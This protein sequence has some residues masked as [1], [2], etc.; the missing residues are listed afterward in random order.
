MLPETI[1]GK[2]PSGRSEVMSDKKASEM[3][4][5]EEV[6]DE[7][8]KEAVGIMYDD[9]KASWILLAPSEEGK[10]EGDR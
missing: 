2:R 9:G 8:V 1:V 6:V 4:R 7:F 5:W 3:E 10:V